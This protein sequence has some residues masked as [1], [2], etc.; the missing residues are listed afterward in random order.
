MATSGKINFNFGLWEKQLT[1]QYLDELSDD[2]IGLSGNLRAEVFIPDDLK[3]EINTTEDSL[4][5][6]P[7]ILYLIS[8][9]LMKRLDKLKKRFENIA[10]IKGLIIV[11]TA[12]GINTKK[13]TITGYYLQS[14]TMES[15]WKEGIFPYPGAVFKRNGLP[16]DLNNDLFEKT[17]GRVFN[18]QYFNKWDMWEWL[19][20]NLFI[21]NHIPH[22]RELNHIANI[23]HMLDDYP[24]I[25]LKPANG[26]QGKGIIEIKR[27]NNQF[28]I[29]DD[30]NIATEMEVI[31]SHPI[32]QSI[33]KRNRKYIIQQGVPVKHDSRNVDFRIYMQKDE[34]KQWKCTGLIARFAKPGSI[35][36]NLHHLDYLLPGKE[37]LEKLFSLDQ[38]DLEL[39]EQK[40][41]NICRDACQALDQ[42][43]CFGDLA[44][45]F[46]LDNNLHVWILEMNKRYGYKSFSIMEEST[47]YSEIIR[48]PFLYASALA[49]FSIESNDKLEQSKEIGS[50]L[51]VE[52]SFGDDYSPQSYRLDE[53]IQ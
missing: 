15:N 7:V 37:A 45:D 1:V 6:G 22:T 41:V 52:A 17:N 30:K 10:S 11:S 48:N 20:P 3:Y 28:Q 44:V 5:L 21:R 19:S 26:S 34:T 12:S 33:L 32:I 18:S 38:H 2:V 8:K 13:N 14:N 31:G 23:Y 40:I 35:T 46:I 39:L 27:K 50:E 47:L 29:T 53:E 4:S 51:I 49:G 24:S 43:G 42:Y 16:Q 25:Y 36:T 9:R